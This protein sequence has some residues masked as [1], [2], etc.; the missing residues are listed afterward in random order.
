MRER[1]IG[2]F[3]GQLP[4][5]LFIALGAMHGNEPAGVFAIE[6][7][8][9]WLNKQ[10]REDSNFRLAG[11]FA[12]LIGNRAALA[13]GKRFQQFDLN[14]YLDPAR[15]EALMLV[16]DLENEDLEA[17]ELIDEM[18]R[19][20]SKYRPA[21]VVI[22]DLHTTSADG[23]VFSI[24]HDDP[25]SRAIALDLCAPVLLGML[26]GLEGTTLHYFN[27]QRL[28]VPSTALVYEAGR[29]DDPMSVDR[30]QSALFQSLCSVGA[31][32]PRYLSPDHLRLLSERMDS[33]P[34]VVRL[35]YRHRIPDGSPFEM[36]PG[37]A[38]FDPI[39]KGQVLAKA[40]KESILAPMDGLILMPLYQGQ[41]S[42]GFFIVREV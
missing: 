27:G 2:R 36:L 34:A 10:A 1:L 32:H 8:L 40:G 35:C 13:S 23:G 14:R 7:M 37:F 25:A 15:I 18:R 33:L 6:R 11:N 22:L 42:D 3:E 30:A 17:V 41:G 5:P 19:L 38:N 29:H 24:V 28:G 12:G 9:A 21:H 16:P 20:L 4:G 31:L 39:S 26:E